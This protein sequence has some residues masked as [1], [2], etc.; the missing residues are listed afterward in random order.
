M[1]MLPDEH[2]FRR[3][4]SPMLFNGL[5]MKLDSI[6]EKLVRTRT[7]EDFRDFLYLNVKPLVGYYSD[8]YSREFIKSFIVING[9]A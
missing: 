5:H 3:Y 2:Y 7:Q 4:Q 8:L 1:L 6:I 9:M